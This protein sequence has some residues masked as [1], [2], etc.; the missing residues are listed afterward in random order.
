MKLSTLPTQLLENLLEILERVAVALHTSGTDFAYLRDFDDRVDGRNLAELLWRISNTAPNKTQSQAAGEDATARVGVRSLLKFVPAPEP[1]RWPVDFFHR[2]MREFFIARAIVRQLT[3]LDST[4]IARRPLA[5][6]P[7]PPEITN[8]AVG[9]MKEREKEA[10]PPP[11]ETELLSLA[12]GAVRGGRSKSV[13]GNA[14]SLLYGLRRSIPQVDFSGLSLDYV[15]LNGAD[16]SGMCFADSSMRYAN[17]DN[18]NLEAA[19]FRGRT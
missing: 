7:L 12:K 4:P 13:G 17:L 6:L 15:D 9:L 18:A 5:A 19:D 10:D 3:V 11:F 14:L 8:F 16:L 2:S 1:K